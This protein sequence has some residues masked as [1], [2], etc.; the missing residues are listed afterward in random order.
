[1]GAAL[2]Q[3]PLDFVIWTIG[4][5]PEWGGICA[6]NQLGNEL[7]KRGQHV[8]LYGD[9]K[10]PGYLGE[11]VR[12]GIDPICVTRPIVIYP[13]IVPD[14]PLGFRNVVRW[15]LN[16][17]ARCGCGDLYGVD[18]LLFLW[19][20][21]YRY[22]SK[23][24]PLGLLFTTDWREHVFY[25]HGERRQ[26]VCYAVRKGKHKPLDQHPPGALC[27][28][29]YGAFGGD[30]YLADLFNR[31]ELF[32]CYDHCTMLS[33]MAAMCGCKSVVIPDGVMSGEEYRRIEPLASV[34]AW[35]FDDLDRALSVRPHIPK[36]LREVDR[37][38]QRSIDS[39]V[40]L[41][42]ERYVHVGRGAH[43]RLY[44]YLKRLFGHSTK[45]PVWKGG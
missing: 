10:P 25:D 45:P 40:T 4:H 31:H 34:V 32:I 13:E 15:I 35:G 17:P 9:S 33:V 44:R 3:K 1:M 7:A 12:P 43:R 36:L 28:D 24:K 2:G 42:Y 18:D 11:L 23:S 20:E 21:R 37:Q 41:C 38:S 14:N 39:F 26:G 22:P 29:D 30:P 5:R 16:L 6:L 27:I 19:S 8:L